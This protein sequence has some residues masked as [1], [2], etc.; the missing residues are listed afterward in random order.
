MS[1]R[2]KE[3]V[4]KVDAAFGESN[5]EGFLEHCNEKIIWTIPGDRVVEGKEGIR[6]F[7]SEM[8]GTEPPKITNANTI[9]EGDLVAANGEMTMKEGGNAV[10][11]AYCDVYRFEGDKI[12]ELKSY[13]VK[14]KS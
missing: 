10:Q 8:K 2:N 13:V 6:Q 11:Y 1:E 9:A 5:L 12:I 14:N 4:R 3:I 7:M